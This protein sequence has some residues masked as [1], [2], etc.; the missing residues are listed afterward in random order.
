MVMSSIEFRVKTSAYSKCRQIDLFG[1]KFYCFPVICSFINCT[2][3]K[4][5]KLFFDNLLRESLPR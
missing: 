3:M 1:E 5:Q 2:Y 4:F